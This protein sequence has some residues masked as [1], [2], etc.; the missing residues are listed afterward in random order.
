MINKKTP[1]KAGST[2][3]LNRTLV[4]AYVYF[5]ADNSLCQR[6]LR[7]RKSHAKASVATVMVTNP[8][9]AVEE[10][11]ATILL[12]SSMID[13][14]QRRLYA[15]LESLKLGHGGDIHIASLLEMDPLSSHRGG[16]VSS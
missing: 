14:K 2:R 9:I 16:R 15:G 5:S 12:F 13:E 7:A 3:K 6:Q 8:D 1:G 10:A 11:K 4:A